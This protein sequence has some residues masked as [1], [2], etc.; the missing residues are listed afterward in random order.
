[1][2]ENGYAWAKISDTRYIVDTNG[3]TLEVTFDN[4]QEL[5]DKGYEPYDIFDHVYGF[6]NGYARIYLNGK[7][8][9][10]SDDNRLLSPNQWYD[11]CSDFNGDGYA[12]ANIG[13]TRY[14]VDTNGNTLE[15][16]FDNAQELLDKG[17]NPKYLFDYVD[18]FLSA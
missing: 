6:Y 9:W 16:T 11:N 15:V 18:Y 14:I 5:L 1:M 12:W 13:D 17:Y 4:V 7:W 2:V 10:V 8:N 3:N